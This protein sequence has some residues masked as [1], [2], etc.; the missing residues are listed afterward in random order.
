MRKVI[1][2]SNPH[3]LAMRRIR[4][5]HFIGI[6]GVGMAGI[7]EVLYS[8]GY[9][10]TGS[11]IVENT[12]TQRLSMLGVEIFLGHRA[13]NV[14]G[15][16][17]VVVSSAVAEDNPEVVLAH[18]LHIPVVGRAQMLAELMRFSQ[19][20]AIAGTHGKTTTTSLIASILSEGGLNPTFVIGGQLNSAGANAVL[21]SGRYFI[22]E[23]DE[24]DASFLHLNPTI[25]VV[26]NIDEDHMTTY[27]GELAN[28]K[29]TFLEFVH[30]LPFYG[31]AVLC[32]D[33][34]GVRELLGHIS[35][36]TVT[37]GFHEDADY[38]IADFYQTGLTSH[39]RLLLPDQTELKL[40]LNLPGLHNVQNAVAAV[41]VAL[42]CGV[43]V[44]AI[45]RALEQ[46]AGV[47]RRFQ[48]YG[49]FDI[50]AGQVTLV[51]DYG[52]HPCEIK[53]TLQAAR[54]A[55]PSKRIVH[56][57]QPHRYTRTRDLF[58]EFVE[59]LK[60]SD[61]VVLMEVHAAGE[62]PIQGATA[63]ALFKSIQKKGVNAV[64]VRSEAQ[65]EHTLRTLLA[66]Q[67]ILLLQGAGGIGGVV[68]RFVNNKLGFAYNELA[69]AAS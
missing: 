54:D 68:Q 32:V 8:Q 39:F 13:S 22:A 51:D 24:S 65:L 46:F 45:K 33:D 4:R 43:G 7:A 18:Q 37:Y 55:W 23:A 64:F 36:P 11:D 20:V 29:Q 59:A 1:E 41:A 15:A 5:I 63:S 34:L 31:L 52:H 67:D 27:Q 17:V 57:F 16:D 21:G 61:V 35:C 48:V 30:N 44:T 56:V 40:A 25:A 66:D 19:G 50:P 10:I 58:N 49:P 6:G 28:L 60:E 38:R 53:M 47:G 12:L 9:V 26:T 42:D 3:H 62:A 14:E 69:G 2:E